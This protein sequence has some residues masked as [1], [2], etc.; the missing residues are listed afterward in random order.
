[1]S[2]DSLKNQKVLEDPECLPLAEETHAGD[3]SEPGYTRTADA[4]V[5]L[6]S[7]QRNPLLHALERVMLIVERPINWLVGALQLNPFYY[8]GPIVVFLF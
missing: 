1:M 2:Q 3:T 6:V 4:N 8:T 7:R 5:E